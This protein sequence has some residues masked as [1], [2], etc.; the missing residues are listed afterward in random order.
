M[1][2]KNDTEAVF[3][4]LNEILAGRPPMRDEIVR[5]LSLPE[6]SYAASIVRAAGNELTRRRF[7]GQTML[8]QQI[9]VETFP[10][11]A[12]CQFCVFGE[13]HSEFPRT[14]FANDE[15]IGHAR[16]MRGERDLFAL[17]V[18]YMHTY[19]FDPL[20]ETASL[21]SRE[22]AGGP[23]LVVNIGD[24]DEGQARALKSAGVSGAYHVRRLGEGV[25]TKL[26]PEQRLQT[27]RAIRAAGLDWY[28]CVEPVGPEH[29]PEELADQMLLGREHGCFQ[30][31]AMRRVAVPG[32][33]LA[34]AG[35][36]TELRL[37]EITAVTALAMQ[38]N[39]NL[40]AVAVHEPNALGLVSGANSLYAESG[41]NPRD[42]AARTEEGRGY[43]LDACRRLF[44]EAGF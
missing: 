10:C 11:P 16:R 17:F 25:E 43:D 8:L 6:G 31:A 33:P 36:I 35:Q 21:L 7:G 19:D 30:H 27:I 23:R 42:A 38:G 26:V 20:L 9:G 5:L 39:A 1:P 15:L 32:S 24:F 41:A 13:S 14:R 40:A 3:P 29:T 2:T 37:A 22:L 44:R 28:N 12:D 34:P 4:L 18:M